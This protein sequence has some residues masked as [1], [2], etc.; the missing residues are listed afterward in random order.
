MKWSKL[1]SKIE[2]MFCDSLK[3]RVSINSTRYGNCNCGKATLSLDK[4]EIA[5]YCTRAFW[6]TSPIQDGNPR[7]Y[8]FVQ[9]SNVPEGDYKKFLNE[10]G[11][12]SRQD[13]YE[14][15][16]DYVHTL[17]IEELLSSKNTFIQCLAVIDKRVGKRRLKKIDYDNLSLVAKKLFMERLKLELPTFYESL[18]L[19]V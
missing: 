7:Q 13:V 18:K 16:F 17:S 15:C 10:Y 4:E 8:G 1:K 5:N 3:K 19:K 11:E 9:G 14:M 12:F 2:N 6:N